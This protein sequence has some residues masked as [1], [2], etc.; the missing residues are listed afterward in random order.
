MHSAQTTLIEILTII[1]HSSFTSS[2]FAIQTSKNKKKILYHQLV[3][4]S[5]SE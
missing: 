2:S 1:T 5:N 3:E 4:Y